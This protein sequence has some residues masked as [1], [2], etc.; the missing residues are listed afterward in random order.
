M[1]RRIL[2]AIAVLGVAIGVAVALFVT[3]DHGDDAVASTSRTSSTT[4][5]TRSDRT[6][7]RPTGTGGATGTTGSGAAG[8]ASVA[9]LVMAH[10]GGA[11]L[12]AAPGYAY[13][14]RTDTS[15][16]LAAEMPTPWADVQTTE[17]PVTTARRTADRRRPRRRRTQGYDAPGESVTL[18]ASGGTTVAAW[19]RSTDL[20]ADCASDGPAPFDDGVFRGSIQVWHGCGAAPGVVAVVA[21][22]PTG[23]PLSLRIVVQA[24]TTADL[25]ALDH[26]LQTFTVG[27]KAP[28]GPTRS[29]GHA[30][31]MV[32]C[33]CTSITPRPRPCGPKRSRRC[34]RSSPT[35][36]ATRRAVT[37]RRAPARTRSKPRARPSPARW[38]PPHPRSCSR[39]AG[40]RPTTSR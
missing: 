37:A 38:R 33:P 1:K 11:V 29:C 36:P 40:A 13:T 9:D 2:L 32:M 21:V 23:N 19:L 14:V 17:T 5:A 18:D 4:L 15:G 6:R 31:T 22:S 28:P 35:I 34:C 20:S 26:T 16:V 10:A 25:A 30:R 27:T 8:T 24:A 39:A 3:R 12:A 7:A